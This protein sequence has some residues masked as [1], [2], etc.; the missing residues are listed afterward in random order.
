MRSIYCVRKIINDQQ[1]IVGLMDSVADLCFKCESHRKSNIQQERTLCRTMEVVSGSGVWVDD[2]VSIFYIS[3]LAFNYS[4]LPI[5]QTFLG[6]KNVHF[7]L[8]SI[9]AFFSLP[10]ICLVHIFLFFLFF[11]V[12]C[13]KCRKLGHKRA[14]CPEKTERGEP[15]KVINYFYF[16]GT[17][18][19]AKFQ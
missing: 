4:Q 16:N 6:Y 17:L 9:N 10:K 2:L 11:S 5:I 19:N 12:R 13:H 3:I 14:Q 15:K 1:T 8:I 7:S 18:D